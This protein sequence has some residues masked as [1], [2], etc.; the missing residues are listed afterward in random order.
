MYG[1]AFQ[2]FVFGVLGQSPGAFGDYV[3]V[4][5][6]AYVIG[7]LVVLLPAGLG[8]REGALAAGL[9]ML[10]LTTPAAALVIAVSYRLWLTVLEILPAVIYLARGARPQPRDTSRR[11]GSIL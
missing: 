9:P 6:A 2:R 8:A 1:L 3:A 7:Y 10:Q 11:D 5:A 4:W